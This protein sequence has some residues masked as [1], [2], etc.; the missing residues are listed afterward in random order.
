VD[1]KGNITL[2]PEVL[3]ENEVHPGDQLEVS[4]EDGSIVL[5]K[6]TET[7]AETVLEI[8]RSLKGLPL[9]ER[10]RSAVRDLRL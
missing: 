6:R 2:P 10:G 8:L 5:R 9:P 1:Q 3:R 4:M 7:S